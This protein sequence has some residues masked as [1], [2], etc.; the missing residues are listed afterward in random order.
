VICGSRDVRRAGAN[1]YFCISKD[2]G[3]ARFLTPFFHSGEYSQCYRGDTQF[4]SLLVSVINIAPLPAAKL[5]SYWKR[6]FFLI[7]FHNFI[8]QL[9]S[10]LRRK[11]IA[12]GMLT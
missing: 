10:A 6:V 3:T 5:R 12:I 7:Y 9:H 11:K 1:F 8:A 4:E 2:R